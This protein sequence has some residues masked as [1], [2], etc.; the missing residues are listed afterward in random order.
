MAQRFERAERLER[1]AARERVNNIIRRNHGLAKT[2]ALTTAGVSYKMI[3]TLV[4]RG[5]LVRAKSGYYTLP[6]VAFSEEEAIFARFPDGVLTMGTALYYHGYLGERP[7]VWSIAVSKNISKSKFKLEKPPVQP[8]FCEENV[9]SLGVETV[10]IAGE[11][12]KIYTVDRLICDVF[13]Y[14]ER[15][16]AGEFR[17]AVRAYIEDEHKDVEKLWEYAAERRVLRMAESILGT[18]IALPDEEGAMGNAAVRGV[19]PKG[20]YHKEEKRGVGRNRQRTESVSGANWRKQTAEDVENE[21]SASSVG[22]SPRL[23]GRGVQKRVSSVVSDNSMVRTDREIGNGLADSSGKSVKQAVEDAGDGL[24][25]SL[26]NSPEQT[27]ESGKNRAATSLGD[28]AGVRSQAGETQKKSSVSA[29]NRAGRAARNIE[30]EGVVDFAPLS[31]RKA[32]GASPVSPLNREEESVAPV[33]SATVGGNDA[34]GDVNQIANAVF[35]ILRQME[36]VEDMGVFVE[37]YDLLQTETVDGMAISRRLIEIC[38]DED[39]VPDEARVK[40]IHSWSV[41]R[42]MEQKWEKYLR[43]QKDLSLSWFKVIEKLSTFI[44]P[45]GLSMA[46]GQPFIGDW[47]PEIG[48]FLE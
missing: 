7:A 19:P 14:R 17:Q 22:R 6:D 39:F 30:S 37:L 27:G 29:E 32:E 38:E 33:V 28:E 40:K 4:E 5:E 3:L 18:W 42:F 44:V 43:R 1:E 35:A 9:L 12:M 34:S 24:P 8:Y 20:D 2:A 21:G 36:L 41:D 25:V 45:I 48:R 16:G 13:K 11:R 47:M 46:A 23:T 10:E 26:D 31:S 15:L